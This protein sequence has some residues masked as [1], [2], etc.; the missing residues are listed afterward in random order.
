MITRVEIWT[1]SSFVC[2]ANSYFMLIC[3]L[4]FSFIYAYTTSSLSSTFWICLYTS[5]TFWCIGNSLSPALV[6]YFYYNSCIILSYLCCY[7]FYFSFWLSTY[8]LICSFNSFVYFSKLSAKLYIFNVNYSLMWLICFLIS[9]FVLSCVINFV[10][11]LLSLPIVDY[12]I[13]SFFTFS[14]N[15]YFT[16]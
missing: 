2:S 1:I 14:S 5:F 10:S 3:W 15:N 13:F 9:M 8:F 12:T 4:L 16:P 7:V 11:S 6:T